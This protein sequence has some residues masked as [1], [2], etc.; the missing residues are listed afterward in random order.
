MVSKW[1]I[2]AGGYDTKVQQMI[3]PEQLH[4]LPPPF[5]SPLYILYS[6]FFQFC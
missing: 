3:L 5:W 1:R 2:E 4:P 6:L